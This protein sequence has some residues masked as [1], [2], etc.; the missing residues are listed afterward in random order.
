ML[1]SKAPKA[2]PSKDLDESRLSAC[3]SKWPYMRDFIETRLTREQIAYLNLVAALAESNCRTEPCA[4]SSDY[5]YV[6]A[7]EAW[8]WNKNMRGHI[9]PGNSS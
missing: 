3:T 8:P 5:C 1:D 9:I 7:L 4:A 2:A 6:E